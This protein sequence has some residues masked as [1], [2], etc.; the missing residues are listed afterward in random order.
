MIVNFIRN[1]YVKSIYIINCNMFY[2][3]FFIYSKRE[4]KEEKKVNKNLKKLK[5]IS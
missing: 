5:R 1:K 3:E 4:H 2:F